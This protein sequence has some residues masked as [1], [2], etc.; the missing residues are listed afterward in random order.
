MYLFIAF[1]T[2][3]ILIYYN[4]VGVKSDSI[5]SGSIS[6]IIF[7]ILAVLIRYVIFIIEL[8]SLPS[9]LKKAATEYRN[10]YTVWQ[11]SQRK[12]FGITYN[13]IGLFLKDSSDFFANAVPSDKLPLSWVVANVSKMLFCNVKKNENSDVYFAEKKMNEIKG[14][15]SRIVSC[16]RF[17]YITLFFLVILTWYFSYNKILD[18]IFENPL[19]HFFSI[20]KF[21][22]LF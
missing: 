8:G 4:I 7:Y 22:F 13:E 9:T 20:I 14:K 12:I 19:L 6:F 21:I 11:K 5:F 16:Y 3:I 15:I 2:L 18:N 10:K 17:Y 1:L